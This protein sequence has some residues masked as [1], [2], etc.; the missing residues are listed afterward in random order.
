MLQRVE[1]QGIKLPRL[2]I[3]E[4]RNDVS[5]AKSRGIPFVRWNKGQ[6]ELIR[7]ILRPLL[8]KQFPYIRWNDVLGPK[9]SFRSEV[10]QVQGNSEGEMP[11]LMDEQEFLDREKAD[12][13]WLNDKDNT[14]L[15]ETVETES[16]IVDSAVS[17][18]VCSGGHD[19]SLEE[20]V[21]HLGSVSDY[22]GDVMSCIDLEVL[23]K[24]GML[25][26]FLGDITDCIKRNFSNNMKWTEGYNKKLGV[27]IGK[28]HGAGY[29]KNLIILD[30]SN[31][32]PRGI[33]A[34]MISLIETLRAQVEADLIITGARSVF[35][36]YKDELPDPQRIRN[37]IG[38]GNE[39]RDFMNIARTHIKGREYGHVIS[40]GDFDSPYTWARYE[41]GDDSDVDKCFAGTKVHEVH[42]Y[43]TRERNPTGYARWCKACSPNVIEHFDTSWCHVMKER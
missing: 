15:E 23:Q 24:L 7:C 3:A 40:F 33:S 36:D 4:N 13:Q 10:L 31:S 1:M 34:T 16:E 37:T 8:E 11:E 39:A 27:P 9:K 28:F 30:I 22:C 42:H 19:G 32:I 6:E 12:K 29:L 17:E 41:C 14:E 38:L 2:Y 26:H 25:P 43:H 20:T 5:L 35:F 18:R 21:V